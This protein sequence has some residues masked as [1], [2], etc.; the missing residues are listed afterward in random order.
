MT[1]DQ[2]KFLLHKYHLNPNKTFGQNFLL[3]DIVLQDTVDASGVTAK[4]A[5]LEV[6]PGIATLTKYLLAKAKFVLAVEKDKNFLPLLRAVKKEHGNF[7]F[8]IDDILRFDFQTDLRQRGYAAYRV[9]ANIPYY[10]TGK[11]IQLFL[12]AKHKPKSITLLV[13]KEVAQNI[14]AKP[15]ALNLL[16]IS[17]QLYGQPKLVQAIPARSFFPAPKVDSALVHINLAGGPLYEVGDE[18]KLFRVLRACFAGKRK[19]IHNTLV[20]NL[21]LEKSQ[22]ERILQRANIEPEARPQQLTIDQWLNLV[23]E[24]G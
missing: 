4:D 22:V 11:I 10:I 7:D 23:K 14:V 17:V 6:G 15:G 18:K 24:I 13:Q 16:A 1:I 5:V 21:K 3:D 20:N 12:R 8:V 19:Q 9:V 2:L